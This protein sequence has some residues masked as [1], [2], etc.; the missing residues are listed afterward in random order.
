MGEGKL[1]SLD[2]IEGDCAVLID[3]DDGSC[4]VSLSVLPAGACEGKMYRKVGD[5]YVED[6]AAEQARRER[7]QALQ[8]RLR[9][10]KME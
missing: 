1:L 2:R 5:T 3:D 8:N 7:V 10:R 4:A 6:P 9:R